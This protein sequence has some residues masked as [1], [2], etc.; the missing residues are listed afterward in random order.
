MVGADRERDDDDDRPDEDGG[1][2]GDG[3]PLAAE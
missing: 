3:A 2:E 1:D